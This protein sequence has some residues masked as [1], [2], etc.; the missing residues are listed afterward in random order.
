M[1]FGFQVEVLGLEEAFLVGQGRDFFGKGLL[2][3][4]VGGVG[5]L[6]ELRGLVELGVV[7]LDKLVKLILVM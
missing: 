3:L 1:G 7:A 5:I 2:G 4:V 6:L